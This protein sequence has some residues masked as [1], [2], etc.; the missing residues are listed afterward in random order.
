MCREGS[1]IVSA[2]E[3]PLMLSLRL[4]QKKEEF[5]LD[6]MIGARVTA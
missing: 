6:L 1:V 4:H 3:H 2:P 5:T